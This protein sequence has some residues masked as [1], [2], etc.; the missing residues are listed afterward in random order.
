MRLT[1]RGRYAVRAMVDLAI[2]GDSKPT[3]LREISE[4]QAISEKYLEQLFRRLRKAGLIQTIRGARGGYILGRSPE[5]ISIGEILRSAGESLITVQ[6]ASGKSICKRESVCTLKF[7]WKELSKKI[8][9]FLESVTLSDLC[10]KA[11]EGGADE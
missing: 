10:Q 1:T 7:Y 11:R 9:E 6:C 3:S 2:H 4:R 5:F 8:R